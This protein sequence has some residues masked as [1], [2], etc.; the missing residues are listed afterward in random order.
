MSTDHKVPKKNGFP[1]KKKF[2]K[3]RGIKKPLIIGSIV[4]AIAVA[5]ILGGIFF[6]GEE[7]GIKEK[8]ILI[9]GV[10]WGPQ[11]FDPLLYPPPA[12]ENFYMYDQVAEGLFD[13]DNQNKTNPV[14]QN[15]AN[16]S[17]WSDDSMNLTCTLREGIRFHDGTRFNATAVKWTI[18]RVYRLLDEASRWIPVLWLLSDGITPIVN[19]TIVLDEY[20]VRFVLNQPFIPFQSLLFHPSSYILSPSSTP[21]NRLINYNNETLIGTGPFILDSFVYDHNTTL[22]ANPNYWGGRPAVDEVIF[23]ASQGNYTRNQE[24][25][26]SGELSFTYRDFGT[27]VQET[28]RNA[29]ITVLTI[30]SSLHYYIT[31]NYERVNVTMRKAI[32]YA[33]NYTHFLEE[34]HGRPAVKLKSYVPFPFLYANWTAFDVP[35]Y[36]VIKARQTLID[37][38]WPGTSG[39]T[40]ND[41]I[42]P[43]NEWEM[44]ANSPTPLATYNASILYNSLRVNNTS[45]LIAENLKQIGVKVELINMSNND[46][47]NNAEEGKLDLVLGGY[48]PDYNDP[49]NVLNPMFSNSSESNWQHVNDPLIQQLLQEGLEETDPIARKQIYY[50]L[51]QYLI[52]GVYPY[53][54]LS[55]DLTFHYWN[56]NVQGILSAYKSEFSFLLKNLYLI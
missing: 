12:F 45:I 56:P 4:A 52:E 17:E 43:G 48:Y 49:D 31:M 2:S 33:F 41:D 47:Y 42:S 35:D 1:P 8:K 29:G 14:V 25:M 18:D 55:A 51:Q 15:L 16:A 22:I 9:M 21:Y 40:V 10:Y 36:D 27:E 3:L 53:L 34:V 24:E 20:T 13:Y 32:S 6:L 39:L 28:F 46:Y 19:E 30:I 37:V 5:G 38:N 54:L 7:D 44:K 11:S 23:K 50:D 26:L